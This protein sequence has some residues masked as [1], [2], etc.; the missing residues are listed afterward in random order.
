MCL[1]GQNGRPGTIMFLHVKET[2]ASDDGP[3]N[4]KS[5]RIIIVN[6]HGNFR[7]LKG[8]K[9]LVGGSLQQRSHRFV[10]ALRIFNILNLHD[11]REGAK[12]D[13]FC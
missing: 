4:K 6:A 9:S 7:P 5:G 12:R 13:I 8:G 3:G 10:K 2:A 11:A 1:D